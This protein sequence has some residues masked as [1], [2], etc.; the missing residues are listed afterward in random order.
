[1]SDDFFS[2]DTRDIEAQFAGVQQDLP[3]RREDG[4]TVIM[5][6]AEGAVKERFAPYKDGELAGSVTGEAKD[7]GETGELRTNGIEYAAAQEFN[8]EFDHPN[9]GPTGERG[10]DYIGRGIRYADEIAP[11]VWQRMHDEV[12]RDNG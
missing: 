2:V 8:H 10:A 3:R 11:E 5:L 12:W 1:M 6:T 7:G 4:M 9:A